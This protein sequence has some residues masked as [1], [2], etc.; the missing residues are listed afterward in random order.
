MRNEYQQMRFTFGGSLTPAVKALL[1]INGLAFFL[2]S[3][4]DAGLRNECHAL[5]GLVPALVTKRL[6]LWQ[7]VTYLFLHAGFVHLS[8]N[9]LQ[10]WWFGADLERFWGT[11]QFLAYYFFTGVGAAAAAVAIAPSSDTVTIG[12]SGAVFGLLV[13]YAILF[14]NRVIYLYFVIPV[15]AKYLVAAMG[16]VELLAVIH[17]SQGGVS[18][19]AHFGGILFGLLW[20]GYRFSGLSPKGVWQSLQRRRLRRKLR[21]VRPKQEGDDDPFGNYS[22]KTLH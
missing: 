4:A 10:V 1:L 6:A 20:F 9:M 14:P 15:K 3:L 5:L 7:P 2:L 19:I 21:L 12:A 13:A 18:N 22:N 8:L 17:G 11:R 16:L